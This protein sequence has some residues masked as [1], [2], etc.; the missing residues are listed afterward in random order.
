MR[1]GRVLSERMMVLSY[2][3]FKPVYAIGWRL[4]NIF[5]PRKETVF[6]CHTAV[7]MEIWGPVQKYLK[8]L[9]I[10]TDKRKTREILRAKG[11]DC[12]MLPVF[13]KAVIMCRVGS[14]KFPS[15]KVI[16]IG[17]THG[18]YH[19]KRITSAK[20]YRP[21]S[22]YLFTS[23][24][25]LKN[26]MQIGV[27]CGK[28]CGYAKL[29]PYINRKLESKGKKPRLLFTATYDKSG[30]SAVVQWASRLGEL[31]NK[32]EIYATL[33][34]WMSKS[35]VEAV[36]STPGVHY[37]DNQSPLPYILKSDLCIADTSSIIADCVAFDKP[38]ITW[39][40]PKTEKTV[41][42]IIEVL[43]R[44]S[45][46]IKSFEELEPA[47]DRILSAPDEKKKER[48]EAAEMF[49][50]DLDGKAGQ[51]AAAEITKL[52]PELQLSEQ[53]IDKIRD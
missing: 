14:H 1:C 29:D 31:T 19:F 21:F 23:K 11:Y 28:A 30:M 43:E 47:I 2:Y 13:P 39:V 32:Y 48:R 46:R 36:S 26:A 52:L 15:N 7:D 6:Y 17:M 35:H 45:L 34:P 50:D 12:K 16:K 51:R 42:E 33:H 5:K 44:C 25:D 53:I 8:P 22:L 18:A 41:D 9:P 27:K 20:N 49:F 3:L 10:V 37:I 38:L 4:L 24:A 40:L